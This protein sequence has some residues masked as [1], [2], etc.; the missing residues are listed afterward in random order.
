MKKIADRKLCKASKKQKYGDKIKVGFIV[1]MPEIWDKEAPVF[2]AMTT[3]ELFDPYLIVVPAFDFV[4]WR[5]GEYG[6]E[7]RYFSDKYKPDFI[8]IAWNDGWLNL[9][10]EHFDYIFYQRPWEQY[11]PRKYHA[12]KVIRYAKTCYIPYCYHALSDRKIYY[13]T[14]F[15]RNLYLLFCCSQE[16]LKSQENNKYKIGIFLGFPVLEQ[17]NLQVQKNFESHNSKKFTVLWTPRWTDDKEYGGTTFFRYMNR[18]LEIKSRYPDINLLLRPHPFT[19]ANAIKTRKLTE[20]EINEY[21]R[22]AENCGAKFD[23][24]EFINN[25]FKIT[26]ILITDFSSII[27]EYF[28]YGNPII[29]CSNVELNFSKTY[30]NIIDCTYV[31]KNWKEVILYIEEIKMG[32]DFLKPKRKRLI[33]EITASHIDSSS[34]IIEYIEKNIN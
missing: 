16:Q 5:I 1:Q 10:E 11:L 23:S 18:I 6:E 4:N 32:N 25:T 31:A 27:I 30:K 26:D 15:F 17:I 19:F 29:Y 12:Y 28:L 7:Y 24:N 3:N 34:K 13:E 8:I 2:E 9:E 22:F 21:K 33:R 20:L 14:S